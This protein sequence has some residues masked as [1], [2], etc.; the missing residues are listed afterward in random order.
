VVEYAGGHEEEADEAAELHT[1]HPDPDSSAEER[2]D[3]SSEEGDG[4]QNL[5]GG[6]EGSASSGIPEGETP[7]S[8]AEEASSPRSD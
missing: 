2:S 4:P 8:D 7:A 3:W 5:T 6:G 1:V